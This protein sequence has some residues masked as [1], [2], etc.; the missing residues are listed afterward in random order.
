MAR[1]ALQALQAR[2]A[3]VNWPRRII[4]PYRV[5]I[6]HGRA[7]W[8]QLA[9]L[10]QYIRD[11]LGGP[12]P[13]GKVPRST[14]PASLTRALHCNNKCE[15]MPA[16]SKAASSSLKRELTS[17]NGHLA[18]L[19]TNNAE[20]ATACVSARCLRHNHRHIPCTTTMIAT[21]PGRPSP[22]NHRPSL[23]VGGG[24][25]K[26][27]DRQQQRP[28]SRS[29]ASRERPPWPTPPTPGR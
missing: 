21:R 7:G 25:S 19:S 20:R 3:V 26:R 17:P 6:E 9:T 11:S 23:R 12:M 22:R 5:L 27:P 16:R 1:G 14:A 18:I 2:L 28:C 8:C 29:T 13:Y 10:T 15:L 4:W 24:V